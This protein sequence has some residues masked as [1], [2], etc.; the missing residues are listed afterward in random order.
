MSGFRLLFRYGFG[1]GRRTAVIVP[2][3]DV[4]LHGFAQAE[5]NRPAAV[6]GQMF[7][8][9][10]IASDFARH[11]AAVG[12][13]TLIGARS[14]QPIRT[15]LATAVARRDDL[16]HGQARIDPV[17]Q[18]SLSLLS[19]RRA[20]RLLGGLHQSVTAVRSL[21]AVQLR[22]QFPE[23]NLH[24]S[25]ARNFDVTWRE[26]AT[27]TVLARLTSRTGSGTATGVKGEGNWVQQADLVSIAYQAFDESNDNAEVTDGPETVSIAG[28]ILD[29]PVTST[30]LWTADSTGYNFLHDL[31][32]ATFPEGGHLYRVEYKFTFAGGAI[33]WAVFRGE[34]LEVLSA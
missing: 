22:V 11:D 17:A 3:A 29:T 32:P 1:G 20:G 15:G 23:R 19:I 21:A 5:Q 8:S 25:D 24:M 12:R 28:T 2:A 14:A 18:A 27:A 13:T 9:R 4:F 30:A 10:R 26:A 6:H 34:A 31:P 7:P 16:A 33:G